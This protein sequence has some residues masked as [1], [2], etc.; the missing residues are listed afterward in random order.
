MIYF[1]SNAANKNS[2][3]QKNQAN[4]PCESPITKCNRP[5]HSSQSSRQ[6]FAAITPPSTRS[7]FIAPTVR[8]IVATGQRRS[9]A[10]RGSRPFQPPR[11]E[12][13]D[14]HLTHSANQDSSPKPSLKILGLGLCE[15]N[16]NDCSVGDVH[17]GINNGSIFGVA[18]YLLAFFCD[19]PVISTPPETFG[20]VH[21]HK[22]S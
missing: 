11:S 21:G 15:E 13:A 19:N 16:V 10:A 22:S 3:P 4:Q 5:D 18:E 12:G 2:N 20:T 6:L 1:L 17:H 7:V 9:R 14:E 8:M